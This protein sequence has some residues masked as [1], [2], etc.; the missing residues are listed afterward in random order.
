M[1]TGCEKV[2]LTPR[3]HETYRRQAEGADAASCPSVP[4]PS[5]P[6]RRPFAHLQEQ[7]H[8]RD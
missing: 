6:E 1:L 4:G 2:A 5:R 7:C 3:A 8:T